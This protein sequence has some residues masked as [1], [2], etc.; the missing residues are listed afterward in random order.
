V[1]LIEP[2]LITTRFAEAAVSSM[3]TVDQEEGPYAKFNAAVAEATANVYKGPMTRLGGGPET[4]ARAVEKALTRNRPK[5]RYLVTPSARLAVFQRRLLP[6]RAWDAAMG[7][8]FPRP[9]PE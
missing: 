9:R 4:V 6:D 3:E 8:S 2:G 1:V 5:T 7:T